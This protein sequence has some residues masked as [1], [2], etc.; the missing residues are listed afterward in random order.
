MKIKKGFDSAVLLSEAV[1]DF[2]QA[3]KAEGCSSKT[4]RWYCSILARFVTTFQD[5]TM[6]D[7]W[8]RV[9]RQYINELLDPQQRY[10]DTT[11]RPPIRGGYSQNR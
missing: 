4:I 7:V 3:R 2:L 9:I 8:S 11:N 1:Q 5:A 6:Q 10:I